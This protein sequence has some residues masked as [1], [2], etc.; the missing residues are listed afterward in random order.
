[1]NHNLTD[2]AVLELMAEL[3]PP[4]GVPA[5][6]QTAEQLRR[7]M[8][9]NN[10]VF[11]R[12][13]DPIEVH[14]VTDELVPGR[15]GRIAVRIYSPDD[16]VAVVVY[17]HGGAWIVGDLDTHDLVTRRLSRDTRALVVSVEYRMLPEHPFPVPFDDAWDAAVWA[18]S[19]LPDRPFL[20]A[21]DS[22]GGTLAACV[23]LQA[24]DLG[25]P[26]IDAQVLV[27]PGVD[28]NFESPSMLEHGSDDVRADLRFF[29]EGYASTGAGSGSPYAL[30]GRAVSLAG[31]PPA[32]VAIA[33]ND[34]LRSSN[35]EYARRL[36]A[37]GVPV[38]VQ[39]DPELVH[40]W[41]EFAARVPSAD[42]AF[43][44]LADAVNDLIGRSATTT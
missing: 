21:G 25:G 34:P 24:R 37:D 7:T 20:V 1:M 19:L 23:A 27:Y 31:L 6:E 36:A 43:A 44:R 42:R 22:A 8:R 32:V 11:T 29:I 26:A 10:A 3:P 35:E 2:P 4:V 28:E 9:E 40:A 5:A 12:G 30:P 39:L 41:I 18:R 16:P 33:G 14:R 38:T 15:H 13:A 17:Y